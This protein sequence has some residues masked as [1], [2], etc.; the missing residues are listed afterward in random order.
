MN[1]VVHNFVCIHLSFSRYVSK[2]EPVR[3]YD[4]HI[5]NFI[6]SYQIVL[7]SS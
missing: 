7:P 3:F 4:M 5:F 6:G 2:N 1:M